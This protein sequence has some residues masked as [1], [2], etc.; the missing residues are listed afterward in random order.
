MQFTHQRS[1]IKHFTDLPNQPLSHLGQRRCHAKLGGQRGNAAVGDATG[2]DQIKP[3]QIGIDIQRQPVRRH[4]LALS[5]TPIAQILAAPPRT[6]TP[7]KPATRSPVM[8]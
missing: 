7:V 1:Q 3:A 2:H 4:P 6:H 5:L 8:P